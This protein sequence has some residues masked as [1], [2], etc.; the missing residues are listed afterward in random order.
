M[1]RLPSSLGSWLA[2][3]VNQKLHHGPMMDSV[4]PAIGNLLRLRLNDSLSVDG[5][6][7]RDS[8]N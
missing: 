8:F 6:K 3:P 4:R 2:L 5:G 1:I 7:V